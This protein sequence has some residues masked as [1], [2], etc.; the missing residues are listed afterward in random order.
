VRKKSREVD[1]GVEGEMRGG[2]RT[3]FGEAQANSRF[4]DFATR[5]ALRIVLLRSE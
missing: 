1:L 2:W 5:F 4:L 3:T